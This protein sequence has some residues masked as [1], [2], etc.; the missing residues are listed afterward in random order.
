MTLEELFGFTE[1]D[2]RAN[3]VGRLSPTQNEWWQ[4]N[5]KR[6]QNTLRIGNWIVVLMIG[7][8]FLWFIQY[9][10]GF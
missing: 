10:G 5:L 8:T 9:S 1:N 3:R 2:L 6:V 7:A 4:K